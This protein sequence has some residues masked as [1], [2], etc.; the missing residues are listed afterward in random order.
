MK[1]VPLDLWRMLGLMAVL[2]GNS[3]FKAGRARIGESETTRCGKITFND[4]IC[5]RGSWGSRQV[6]QGGITGN[7]VDYFFCQFYKM[8]C[9]VIRN[10]PSLSC[11]M[12]YIVLFWPTQPTL[13]WYMPSQRSNTVVRSES[14]TRYSRGYKSKSSN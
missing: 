9:N 4:Q 11:M 2:Q 6:M 1:H 7:F 8:Q 13:S 14:D 3:R 12:A 10:I 5:S